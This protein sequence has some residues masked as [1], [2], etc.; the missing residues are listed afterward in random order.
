M[1]GE[2]SSAYV[3]SFNECIGIFADSK[4]EL[5]ILNLTV[6]WF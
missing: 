2:R 6:D 5:L 1:E 3:D 4:F